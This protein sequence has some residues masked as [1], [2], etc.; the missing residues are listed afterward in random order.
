M[1]R[2]RLIYQMFNICYILAL[3]I[4]KVIIKKEY[5]CNFDEFVILNKVRVPSMNYF[6][7]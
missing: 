2:I 5:C 3:I 4:N 1:L 6:D 7:Y